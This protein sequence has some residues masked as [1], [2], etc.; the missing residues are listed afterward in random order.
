MQELPFISIIVPVYNVELYIDQCVNSLINQTLKNIEIILVDD[1]STDNSGR[2]C[3]QYEKKYNNIKVIHKKNGGLGN[4]RNAGLEKAQGKYIAFVDSDDY[5]SNNMYKTLYNLALEN[6]SDCVY[7]EWQRFWETPSVNEN[8]VQPKINRYKGNEICDFYLLGRIGLRPEEKEDC[9][10]GASV[11]VGIFRKSIIDDFSIRFVSERELISEDMIFDIDYI[12]HCRNIV[13]TSLPLY[14]YR[15]N[16]NSLT[17]T[18]V[19]NRFEKNVVLW[20]E[21]KKRLSDIYCINGRFDEKFEYSI[22]R[23]FLTFTRISIIEEIRHKK[24]NGPLIAYRNIRRIASNDNLKT[25][26][27]EYPIKKMNLKQHLFFSA[28]KY[29]AVMVLDILVELNIKVRE[30]K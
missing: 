15:Y 13:H 6:D 24:N 29:K 25:I 20:K 5:V 9:L 3:D 26:L 12:Q 7:C 11:C 19:H 17:T 4:A 21:M 18:Y 23:Y 27:N 16:S 30:R 22:D 8:D 2:I 1:E 28:L 14:Y 10:Y